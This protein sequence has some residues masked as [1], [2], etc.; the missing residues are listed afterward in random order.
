[1][2]NG[3]L[4]GDGA[5]AAFGASRLAIVGGAVVGALGLGAGAMWRRGGNLRQPLDRTSQAVE[6]MFEGCNARGEPVAVGGERAHV[7]ALVGLGFAR[8]DLDRYRLLLNT[9]TK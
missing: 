7:K 1:M 8:G 6:F 9:D 2:A 5:A 4:I 3:D